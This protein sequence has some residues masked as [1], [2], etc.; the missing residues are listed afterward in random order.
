MHD[1]AQPVAAHLS[2]RESPHEEP[3]RLLELLS[4]L[5]GRADQ[6]DRLVREVTGD[7]DHPP[8][9]GATRAV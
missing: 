5:I 7:A 3:R 2:S 6:I 1:V 9:R 8:V 4:T